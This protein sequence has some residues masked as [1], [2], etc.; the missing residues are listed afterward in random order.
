VCG[1]GRPAFKAAGINADLEVA[2]LAV[3]DR[4][5]CRLPGCGL[6]SLGARAAPAAL[7]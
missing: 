5:L 3:G 6:R 2:Q 1:E 7:E 4:L